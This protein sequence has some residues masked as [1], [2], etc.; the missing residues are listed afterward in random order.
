MAKEIKI[1]ILAFITIILIIWGYAFVKGE[2]LFANDNSFYTYYSNVS[3]LTVAAP[4]MVNGL[5]VGTVKSIA[6]DPNDVHNIKVSMSIQNKIRI[7]KNTKALLKS[8][9]PLGGR[10]IELKFDKM[11]NGS[12]CAEDGSQLEG[13]EV[14]LINS[15]IDVEEAGEL[16]NALGG[17]IQETISSLGSKDSEATLDKTLVNLESVTHNLTTLTAKIDRLMSVSEKDLRST[18]SNMS[19]ISE[20]IASNNAQITSMISNMNKLSSDLS[21]LDMK[22][23]LDKTNGTVDQATIT[24]KEMEGTMTN[25]KSTLDEFQG[26]ASKI[27]EGDG[28]LSKLMNDKEMYDN[29]NESSKQLSLLLQDFRLNPKRYVN[30][31]VFGKKQKNYTVPENDPAGN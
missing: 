30:V 19:A 4:V 29:L 14:G 13:V 20:N 15:L 2:N 26:L 18:M 21:G 11:C 5:N 25:L 1:G 23:T 16:G 12:D 10:I 3:E 24:L 8:E 9:S 27:S 17:T 22:T 28:T 7:P 6:L 31:S